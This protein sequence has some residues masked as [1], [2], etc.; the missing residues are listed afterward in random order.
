MEDRRQKVGRRM[1]DQTMINEL[2]MEHHKI[3]PRIEERLRSIDKCVNNGLSDELK[4]TVI[5][6]NKFKEE[7]R[8]QCAL[9]E[10]A[11]GKNWFL[12]SLQAGA[13]KVVAILVVVGLF[14]SVASV[15]G[16]SMMRTYG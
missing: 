8:T 11:D 5:A 14:T 13:T 16:Y 12:K 1:S 2:V 4:S 3:L 7:C 10:I 15:I 6:L 9:R